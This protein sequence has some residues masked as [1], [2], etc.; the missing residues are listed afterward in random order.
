[1]ADIIK[2]NPCPQKC[3]EINL[4]LDGVQ[5]SCSST[6]S[7]DIYSV[8]FKNCQCVFPIRLIR[9]V[10]KYRVDNEHFL[11]E[12]LADLALNSTKLNNIIGDSPKRSFLRFCMGFNSYF[13]C[14]YCESP[15]VYIDN[16]AKIQEIEAKFALQKENLEKK[17]QTIDSKPGPSSNVRKRDSLQKLLNSLGP[18][19]KKRTKQVEIKTSVLAPYHLK[20]QSTDNGEY[21]CYC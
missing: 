17:I 9:P 16:T 19:L 10:N 4:S 14:E 7:T 1:M 8:A 15:A 20:W 12:V 3:N 18:K 5:E 21:K 13:G 2:L 11:R 6:I